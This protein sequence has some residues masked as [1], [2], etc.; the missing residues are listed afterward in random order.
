[1][2]ESFIFC[3][4]AALVGSAVMAGIG[5]GRGG[6]AQSEP[7]SSSQALAAQRLAAARTALSLG[8]DPSMK[9][10]SAIV[11]IEAL[12]TDEASQR[13]VADVERTCGYDAPLAWARTNL[14]QMSAG[15]NATACAHVGDALGDL[16][17]FGHGDEP[18]VAEIA[19][20]YESR[21]I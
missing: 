2:R 4:T 17:R 5:C 7:A 12:R 18:P 21:C 14:A 11:A 9:C 13:L 1:M 3:L 10:K 20:A 19:A 16:R 6:A 8:R 15:P